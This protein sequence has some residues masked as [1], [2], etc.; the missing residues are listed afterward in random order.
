VKRVII[1]LLFLGVETLWA[2]D[3]SIGL[4]GGIG[5]NFLEGPQVEQRYDTA[6]VNV[7]LFVDI[8]F[9]RYFALR[10]EPAVILNNELIMRYAGEK[11]NVSWQSVG[12]AILP[13]VRLPL[14]NTFTLYAA[15]GFAII[16]GV[17]QVA[18]S[19]EG[20]LPYDFIMKNPQIHF[21]IEAGLEVKLDLAFIIVGV[22][23]E[24]SVTSIF[25]TTSRYPEVYLHNPLSVQ[26]GLGIRF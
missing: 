6:Q 14:G 8:G 5:Q 12:L 9:I 22:R 15:G 10:F 7:S 2:L 17:G 13:K 25:E 21:P 20:A 24:W 11:Q 26:M 4:K 19:G 3:Y 16:L 1:V 23:S 18:V